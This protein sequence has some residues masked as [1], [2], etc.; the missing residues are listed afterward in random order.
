MA[1]SMNACCSWLPCCFGLHSPG[2]LK[3]LMG[4]QY[5][6]QMGSAMDASNVK[7][8]CHVTSK[9]D[10]EKKDFYIN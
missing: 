10:G 4:S 9:L 5:Y 3:P 7:P 2:S 1:H 8:V 6:V